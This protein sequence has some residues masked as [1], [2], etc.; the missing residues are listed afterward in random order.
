MYALVEI[1]LFLAEPTFI[2]QNYVERKAAKSA[3][4]L[5]RILFK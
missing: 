1:S 5:T 4:F 3:A 2:F